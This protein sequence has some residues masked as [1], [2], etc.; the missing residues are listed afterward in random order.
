MNRRTET[1]NHIA[2]PTSGR[3]DVLGDPEDVVRHSGM[4]LAEKRAVLAGWASDAHAVEHPAHRLLTLRSCA[5]LRRW[6]ATKS[7]SRSGGP[8]LA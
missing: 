8:H 1:Q 5:T 2:G 6:L 7:G 4:T 3:A